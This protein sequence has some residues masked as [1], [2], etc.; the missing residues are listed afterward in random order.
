MSALEELV[1]ICGPDKADEIKRWGARWIDDLAAVVNLDLVEE[2]IYGD[3]R[4][5]VV[6]QYVSELAYALN[7]ALIEHQGALTLGRRRLPD[8]RTELRLGACLVRSEPKP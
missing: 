4:P 6:K 3:R 5:E 8:G 2:F 7:R 1:E